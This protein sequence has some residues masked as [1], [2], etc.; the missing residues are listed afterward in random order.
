MLLLNITIFLT[1]N[2]IIDYEQRERERE[3][4]S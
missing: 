4:E 1:I 2:F 3:R